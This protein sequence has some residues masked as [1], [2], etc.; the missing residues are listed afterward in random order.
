MKKIGL[1][2]KI[3]QK[4]SHQCFFFLTTYYFVHEKV[5]LF[6]QRR[7]VV[8]RN[9]VLCTVAVKRLNNVFYSKILIWRRRVSHATLIVNNVLRFWQ[10]TSVKSNFFFFFLCLFFRYKLSY[11]HLQSFRCAVT[12]GKNRRYVLLQCIRIRTCPVF[13]ERP[14]GVVTYAYPTTRRPPSPPPPAYPRRHL[15]RIAVRPTTA[16]NKTADESG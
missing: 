9:E 2:K 6:F 4:N 7:V 15:C 10:N 16:D 13:V 3:D 5:Y 11:C 1:F 8:N 12:I 14:G